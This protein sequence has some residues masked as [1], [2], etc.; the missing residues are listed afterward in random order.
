MLIFS[1]STLEYIL[2]NLHCVECFYMPHIF[3]GFL[4]ACVCMY[5]CI[6]TCVYVCM[7]VCMD[8]CMYV[9]VCMYVCLFEIRNRIFPAGSTPKGEPTEITPNTQATRH[10][11]PCM[12]V[13]MYISMNEW[14]CVWMNVCR[15]LPRIWKLGQVCV[16]M[17]V[18]KYVCMYVRT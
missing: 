14:M 5:T 18:S 16:Y 6:C 15:F 9:C 7:C 10:P 8:M 2:L 1:T 11:G 3:W 17:Y 4:R 13:C 12:Y